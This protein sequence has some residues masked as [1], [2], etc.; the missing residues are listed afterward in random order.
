[1]AIALLFVIVVAIA[2]SVVKYAF[3]PMLNSGF[4]PDWECTSV[5]KGS[6]CIKRPPANP[7]SKPAPSN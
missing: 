7:A 4:G 3:W 5:G 6:V 1:V 2:I